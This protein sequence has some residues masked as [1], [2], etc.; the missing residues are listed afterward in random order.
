V[1]V[2]CRSISASIKVTTLPLDILGEMII[3]ASGGMITTDVAG[4]LWD[5][6]SRVDKTQANANEVSKKLEDTFHQFLSDES[7]KLSAFK[8][9]LCELSHTLPKTLGRGFS[10]DAPKSSARS[11]ALPAQ[12][13]CLPAQTAL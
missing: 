10:P 7:E 1:I 4:R 12:I 2:E 6:Q 11:P 8:Q 3:Y 9:S 13:D 5:F